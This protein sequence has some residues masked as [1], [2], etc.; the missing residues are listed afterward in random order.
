MDRAQRPSDSECFDYHRAYVA[1]VPDGDIVVTLQAQQSR[2][3]ELL[4]QIPAT[5]AQTIHPPYTW[6]VRQ[7]VEHCVEGER[8]FGYRALRFASGDPTELPGWNENFYA[9]AGYGP[10]GDLEDLTVEFAALRQANLCLLSRL[11]EPAW[12]RIGVAD[13]RRVSVRTLAWLMAGHWNHH[14]AILRKRLGI[15]AA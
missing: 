9:A 15:A 1:L 5:A 2:L 7:V 6:T 8:M 12:N 4:R 10:L 13:G 14:E 3:C 11:A